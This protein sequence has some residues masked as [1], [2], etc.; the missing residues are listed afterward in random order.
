M[1]IEITPSPLQGNIKAIASKSAAHRELIAAAL[2]Q[3]KT[4]IEINNLSEDI[5]ATLRCLKALGA[6][7]TKEPGKIEVKPIKE[8]LKGSLLD[9]G[10]SGTTLRLLLPVAGALGSCSQ[11]IGKGRLPDRPIKELM[12][13]LEK[14]GLQFSSAKLPLTLSESLKGGV[15]EIP[16]NISSQYISG[17]L[18]ALP[19][20]KEDSEIILTS[21]LQSIGYVEMTLEV[22]KRYRITIEKIPSGYKIPGGQIYS[23]PGKVAVEGDW[24]NGAFF[25]AAGAISG[26]VAIEGLD[27]ESTQRDK[28]IIKL[29]SSGGARIYQQ[30]SVI[31]ADHSSLKGQEIDV[32]EIPDLLPILAVVASLSQG[33]TYLKNASRLRL[34]ESDRLATTSS[35]LKAL[36]GTVEEL[37]DG[38]IIKG[39]DRLKGGITESFG[40]HRIAMAAAIAAIRAKDKVIIKDAQAINKSYP[41]FFEDYKALGGKINVINNR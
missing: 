4:K 17:L 19:L 36:G 8:I 34:K 7:F 2:S 5:E 11:V 33:T 39:K 23:S 14:G 26:S 15:Y 29:L 3:D 31:R 24:S 25:I 10:E 1:D 28:E 21:H 27:I 40:D 30:E 41:D 20:L 37:P 22:L 16:G 35:M 9:C 18:F 12:S 38:L 32:S 6:N 13:A